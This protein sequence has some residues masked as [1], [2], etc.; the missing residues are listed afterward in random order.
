MRHE[1]WRKSTNETMT[2]VQMKDGRF[3]T[4][5]ICKSVWPVTNALCFKNLLSNLCE[6]DCWARTSLSYKPILSD[7]ECRAISIQPSSAPFSLTTILFFFIPTDRLIRLWTLGHIPVIFCTIQSGHHTL[8]SSPTNRFYPSVSVG[9]NTN[10][11]PLLKW[12]TK[13]PPRGN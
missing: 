7:C 5:I 10:H 12:Q 9:P 6:C 11:F 3:C 2:H 4:K 8:S 1:I 13:C